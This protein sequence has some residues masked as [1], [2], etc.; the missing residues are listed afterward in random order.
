VHGRLGRHR[1]NHWHGDELLQCHVEGHPA[2][3]G[4]GEPLPQAVAAGRQVQHEDAAGQVIHDHAV[5]VPQVAPLLGGRGLADAGADGERAQDQGG[6]RGAVVERLGVPG[7]RRR[8]LGELDR[9]GSPLDRLEHTRGLA[10]PLGLGRVDQPGERAVGGDL[11]QP[12]SVPVPFVQKTIFCRTDRG[13]ASVRQ[14]S[15]VCGAVFKRRPDPFQQFDEPSAGGLANGFI[16]VDQAD[17]DLGAAFGPV[18]TSDA[19]DRLALRII[20]VV[21]GDGGA[22]AAAGAFEGA[23]GRREQPAVLERSVTGQRVGGHRGFLTGHR[24]RTKRPGRGR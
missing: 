13:F 22:Q 5:R 19:D 21:D 18:L 17:A 10:D 7:H 1:R 8:E 20:G 12:G 6:Q 2:G 23:A 16:E 11:R 9:L 14:P 4:V 24:P 15:P 3:P